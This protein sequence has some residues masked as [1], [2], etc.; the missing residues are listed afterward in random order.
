MMLVLPQSTDLRLQMEAKVDG[1]TGSALLI[2]F[3]SQFA[4]MIHDA[5]LSRFSIYFKR[6]LVG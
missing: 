4:S 6:I 1:G 5:L 2:D 3:A